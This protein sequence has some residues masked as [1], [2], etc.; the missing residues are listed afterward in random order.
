[1]SEESTDL[2]T[3]VV[4]GPEIESTADQEAGEF[5]SKIMLRAASLTGAKIDRGAF[6]RTEVRKRFPEIDADLAVS[7]TLIQAGVFPSD[8]DALALAV[9]E[10]EAQ[11]CAAS[12]F[13]AGILGGIAIAGTIPAD[14]AQYFAHVMHVEQKPAY[15]YG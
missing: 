15:L 1:M 11:K 5:A 10:F 3:E 2:S 4:A 7:T 6:L 14:L 13:V 9:I 8:L 12:S